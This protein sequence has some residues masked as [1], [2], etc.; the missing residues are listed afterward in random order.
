M[1]RF[2]AEI[3]K[4]KSTKEEK[5][6]IEKY[7]NVNREVRAK[8]KKVVGLTL[9]YLPQIAMSISS[10]LI[11]GVYQLFKTKF[12]PKIFLSAEF[13]GNYL[14]YQV[15]VWILIINIITMMYKV[16]KKKN[17]LYVS[18]KKEKDFYV[19]VDIQK[20]FIGIHAS[21]ERTRRKT[22]A[23]KNYMNNKINGILD[24][25]E[26]YDLKEFL[27][28]DDKEYV[29]IP[30]NASKPKT[31]WFIDKVS[32]LMFVL[33]VRKDKNIRKKVNMLLNRLTDEWIERNIESVKTSK[34][35]FTFANVTKEKLISGSK[36]L[37]H[38]DGESD[39]EEHGFSVFFEYYLTGFLFISL[40]MFVI[41]SL[42]LE[43][44]G[45]TSETFVLLGM[46]IF[47]LM[48]N[49]FFTWSKTEETFEKTKLKVLEE[50]TSEL[51]KYFNSSF[52]QE[53]KE[54]LRNDFKN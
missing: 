38:N 34:R 48:F 17:D 52:K 20:P 47:M 2:D 11:I 45:Y 51:G 7:K 36:G 13:W 10:V 31:M 32:Y 12:D 24:K 39:F 28:F 53:E 44:V 37:Q 29:Y 3:E 41:L 35:T 49:A 42:G 8:K 19:T 46:K 23:Y 5:D 25:H 33:S 40:I 4:T 43:P 18:L 16:Y 50:T 15:A 27:E 6:F 21:K 26:I 54:M 22:N 30:K 9:L 1:S 14:T